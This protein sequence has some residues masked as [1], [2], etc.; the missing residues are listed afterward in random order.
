MTN[1][2]PGPWTATCNHISASI[3][4]SDGSV[5]YPTIALVDT[6]TTSADA[7]ARLIAAAPDLLA[8]LIGLAEECTG[9]LGRNPYGVPAFKDA[10]R[11]LAKA[12]GWQ[13][14]WMDTIEAIR[15]ATK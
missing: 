11:A 14:D 8:A 2:T 15:K 5:I 10:L 13:G 6:A 12:T 9:K 4:T 3:T 1:H 7:N